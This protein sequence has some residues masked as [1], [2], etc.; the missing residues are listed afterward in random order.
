MVCRYCGETDESKLTMS[1]RWVNG[2]VETL[3]VC[4][5]CF[6][7]D[8][9]WHENGRA[10]S[11]SNVREDETSERELSEGPKRSSS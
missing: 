11:I 9:S 10:Q 4:V 7:L 3:D 1:S 6:W 2:K 8:K 5:R